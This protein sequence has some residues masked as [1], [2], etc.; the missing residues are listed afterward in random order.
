MH[1]SSLVS[2][3]SRTSPH[4]WQ[5]WYNCDVGL[6]RRACRVHQQTSFCHPAHTSQGNKTGG[7][8]VEETVQHPFS[9]LY[10]SNPYLPEKP[11]LQNHGA[12]PPSSPVIRVMHFGDKELAHGEVWGGISSRLV[13]RPAFQHPCNKAAGHGKKWTTLVWAIQHIFVNQDWFGN[14]S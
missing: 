12:A 8:G 11:L 13:F 14:D 4:F 9:T 6:R 7:E 2:A 1:L 5:S 3:S 10:P